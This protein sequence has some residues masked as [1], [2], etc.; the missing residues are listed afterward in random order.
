[1]GR[2]GH[3]EGA[4]RKSGWKNSETQTIRVPKIFAAQI[5]EY[6]R[7]LDSEP[8]VSRPGHRIQKQVDS[9]TFSELVPAQEVAPGQI[10]IFEVIDSGTESK[11]PPKK[12]D[13][14]RWLSSE[15]AWEV[16]KRRGCAR[17]L[18][19]FRKWSP[20]NPDECLKLYGLLRLPVLVKGNS[21]APAFEDVHY[22]REEDCPDF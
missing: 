5:L 10:S 22:V 16:A 2:G 12:P 4:G 11:I 3:R 8:V 19:G 9:E 7:K 18:E 17:N 21:S 15:Q 14:L 13:G 1:M 20:R 6:A